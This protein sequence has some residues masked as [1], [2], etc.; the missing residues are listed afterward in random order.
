MWVVRSG[1]RNSFRFGRCAVHENKQIN[2]L[3]A[4]DRD[5]GWILATKRNLVKPMSALGR[6]DETNCIKMPTRSCR[7]DA[8]ELFAG[9]RL[10]PTGRKRRNFFCGWRPLGRFADVFE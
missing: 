9:D 10:R 7:N 4:V 1:T 8:V 5:L 6:R 3:A 2:V